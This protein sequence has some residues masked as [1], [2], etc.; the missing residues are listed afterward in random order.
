MASEGRCGRTSQR[1]ADCLKRW[2]APP[3][4]RPKT[5][6]RK[7]NLFAEPLQ[8]LLATPMSHSSPNTIQKRSQKGAQIGV[9]SRVRKHAFFIESMSKIAFQGASERCYF[10]ITV[11]PHS[12]SPFFSSWKVFVSPGSSNCNFWRPFWVPRGGVN[13]TQIAPLR[14]PTGHD[15]PRCFKLASQVDH[16]TSNWHPSG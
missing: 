6:T 8:G 14:L 13:S 15:G 16:Q 10:R 11:H 3:L 2:G 5:I 9:Q 4:M 12:R 7:S 1:V